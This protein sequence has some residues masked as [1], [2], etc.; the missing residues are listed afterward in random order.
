MPIDKNPADDGNL[1]I[2]EGEAR[3]L[4]TGERLREQKAGTTRFKS[5]FATCPN[6]SSHRR[7]K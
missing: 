4:T 6:A 1:V 3:V 2:V 5:H 7:P